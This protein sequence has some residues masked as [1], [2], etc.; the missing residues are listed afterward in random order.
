MQA[1]DCCISTYVIGYI[2]CCNLPVRNISKPKTI[3]AM[4]KLAKFKTTENETSVEA[5]IAG[6][7]PEQKRE[8]SQV[9]I[10]M[11]GKATKEKPKMW[12]SSLIGFGKLIYTSPSGR[13]VEWFKVGFSP[14]KANLSLYFMGIDAKVRESLLLKLGKHKTDGGCVYI[15]KLADVDIEVL[16]ELIDAGIAGK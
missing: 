14:R 9:L 13:A 12:G 4:A 6:V 1:Y 5:F 15:N 16:K 2:S 8:D 11:M 3:I 7:L 10:E